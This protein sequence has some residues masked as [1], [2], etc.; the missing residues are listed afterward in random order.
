MTTTPTIEKKALRQQMAAQ[1]DEAYHAKTRDTRVATAN[2]HL[3]HWLKLQIGAGLEGTVLSGYMPM[4][5]EIDPLPSMAAHP[6]PVCVPV[7]VAKAHPLEFHRWSPE[8]QMIEG[9]FKALIPAIRAPLTPQAM[10]V[11]LLAF[12]RSGYRLGYGGGFYDRTLQALR[13]TGPILAIGFAFDDQEVAQVPR[14][15][16]D[17]RLDAVV[18]PSGVIDLRASS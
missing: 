3:S 4:R 5:T 10:I 14:D 1:R 18:T 8:A 11:P 9:Q 13:A 7:I 16:T 2:A 6:G 17:Q 15:P 12:D